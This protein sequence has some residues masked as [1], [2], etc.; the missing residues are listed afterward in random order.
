MLTVT[1]E[2]K[3][4]VG[5][6]QTPAGTVLRLDPVLHEAAPGEGEEEVV[7]DLVAG[8]PED[9][10]QVVEREGEEVLRIA[11]SVSARLDGATVD[12]VTQPGPGE[13][14]SEAPVGGLG[15]IPP[16]APGV[17]LTDDS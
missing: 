1:E 13:N 16:A 9:G 11:G 14:G 6:Q 10:D 4:L 3:A 5:Q 12:V 15:V 8:A 17:P 7:L 2:A